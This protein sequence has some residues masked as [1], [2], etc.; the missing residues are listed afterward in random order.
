MSALPPLGLLSQS[1]PVLK[2]MN[3]ATSPVNPAIPF[4]I[5]SAPGSNIVLPDS[6]DLIISCTPSIAAVVVFI[7]L[8]TFLRSA[9]TFSTLHTMLSITA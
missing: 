2:L 7:P 6:Q 9:I 4:F 3:N 8:I 1:S 5:K